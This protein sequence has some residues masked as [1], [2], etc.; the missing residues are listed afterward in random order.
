MEPPSPVQVRPADSGAP[1]SGLA[2]FKAAS[3]PAETYL[4]EVLAEGNPQ[5]AIPPV[6][7]LTG[8]EGV[9]DRRAHQ[10][11]AEIEPEEPPVLHVLV[12]LPGEEEKGREGRWTASRLCSTPP[13]RLPACPSPCGCRRGCI[14]PL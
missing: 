11:H 13:A 2:R 3:G 5:A 8:H 4:L 14:C 12:K 10:G 1:V 6:E 9:E 7:H